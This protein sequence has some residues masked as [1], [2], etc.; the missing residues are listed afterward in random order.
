MNIGENIKRLRQMYDLSQKDLA[1]IAGV[2]DK[3]VSTWEN[4]IKEPRM[5]AIQKIADHFGF[6]K[7]N[8]IE[9]DGLNNIG[10]IHNH[11]ISTKETGFILEDID[12]IRRFHALPT[13]GQHMM[14]NT[15]ENLETMFGE[16][17]ATKEELA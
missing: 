7:S 12:L 6:K 14:I 3:A 2:T 10:T 5:G 13:T 9:D 15:L 17:S 8:I 4:G 16:P 11:I 1:E